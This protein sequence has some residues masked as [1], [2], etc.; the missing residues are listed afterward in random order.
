MEKNSAFGRFASLRP[1][2]GDAA[3]DVT[4]ADWA[5]SGHAAPAPGSPG[6][7]PPAANAPAPGA[8]SWRAPAANG[9]VPGS[10]AWDASLGEAVRAQLKPKASVI[11]VAAV[12]LVAVVVVYFGGVVFTSSEL[13]R[14]TW[15]RMSDGITVTLDFDGARIDYDAETYLPFYGNYTMDIAELDYRVIAPGVIQ[16]HLNTWDSWR[17][18]FVSIEDDALTMSPALTSSGSNEIWVR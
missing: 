1:A 9:P 3:C 12:V 4:R 8:S 6:W 5:P 14:G 17:T 11:V 2:P 7:N 10:H 15:F 16:A 13:Q 18:I